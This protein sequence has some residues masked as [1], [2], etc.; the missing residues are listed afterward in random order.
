MDTTNKEV[1]LQ[2]ETQVDVI[3]TK[4]EKTYTYSRRG[5][6]HVIKRSYDVQNMNSIR[7]ASKRD[8]ISKFIEDH[9][10][11][12]SDIKQCHRASKLIDMVKKELDIDI[13]YTGSKSLL[14]KA[15]L[16]VSKPKE[17]VKQSE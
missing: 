3:P 16:F 11:E 12:L 17:E 7:T 8:E 1:E 15:G 9:K 13:S 4:Q 2:V 10:T 5:K 6:P 14:K